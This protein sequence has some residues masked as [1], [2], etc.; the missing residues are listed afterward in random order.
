LNMYHPVLSDCKAIAWDFDQTL[1]YGPKSEYWLKFVES[2]PHI[3]HYIIT[4]RDQID[5]ADIPKELARVKAS[6]DWFEEVVDTPF[7][8]LD[9]YY[10]L[11]E[12]L[13]GWVDESR[14]TPKRQRILK[15]S[16]L[17]FEQVRDINIAMASY[18]PKMAQ[19][20]E[21]QALVDDLEKLISPYCEEY[22]ITF[23]PSLP[24]KSGWRW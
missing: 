1:M 15:R 4:F 19:A 9:P 21:C 7:G 24:A 23:V 18:K 20:L 6:V 2:N 10:A 12:Q 13:I 3:K 5:S 11:H 16:N 17:T 14:S 8:L 22:G